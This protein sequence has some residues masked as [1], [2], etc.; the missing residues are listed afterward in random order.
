MYQNYS[1]TM[2][3]YQQITR[4]LLV[5]TSG[6]YFT[7]RYSPVYAK[8]LTINKGVD[9]VLLFEF[10]NQDQKP[11]NILGSSFVFR[12][13]DQAGT[14]LLVEK[15][16]T[17]LS[18]STGR[19][20]VVLDINDTLDLVAQPASYSIQRTAGDYV[21]AAYVGADA[22]ARGDANVV[23]SVKPQHLPSRELTI[24]LLYGG[25]NQGNPQPSLYYSSEILEPRYLTTVQAFL[26][27][28][29]G[30]MK[31]EGLR[32]LG[33]T[34]ESASQTYNYLAETGWKYWTIVGNWS[35][36]RM[37]FNN[38]LG[39]GAT[40]TATVD[41]QGV[42]TGIAVSNV[43]SN[44]PAAPRVVIVGN[45]SGARA[46]ATASGGAVGSI[47][48]LDGGSGYTGLTLN[49]PATAKVVLDGGAFTAITYR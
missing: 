13:L 25:P 7:L 4:V 47:T 15:P 39:N 8:S 40:A 26:D 27:C 10:I 16:M 17:I 46:V 19:V 1:T 33:E 20:K 44:Y 18:A 34:W 6:G 49:N 35:S 9:N 5:D 48:L 42:V 38:R 12:L 29:T 36:L 32:E 11:V 2:Y 43:G 21:Q 37:A 24:P 41:T 23:D 45:G 31:F 28:Y 22:T 3:V 14:T 30:T